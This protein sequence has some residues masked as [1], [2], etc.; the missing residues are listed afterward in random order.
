[1][2]LQGPVPI[3]YVTDVETTIRFYCDV[4]GFRCANRFE[5]WASLQR[6]SAEIMLSLPNEHLPFQ[7]SL[8][9]GSFYFHSDDV[10]ALWA[11]LRERIDVVYPIEN[12]DYGMR[13]FAIRDINGYVLQFGQEIQSP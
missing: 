5:G 12:F 8:F 9:T 6:D 7:K 2:P 4:L 1:M 3:L 11:Q 10:D 13:E